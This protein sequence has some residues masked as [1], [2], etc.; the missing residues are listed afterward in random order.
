MKIKIT[1]G[2]NA[3]SQG[4]LTSTFCYVSTAENGVA[5]VGAHG[6]P[7]KVSSNEILNIV[8]KNEDKIIALFNF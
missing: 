8:D 7:Q 1:F 4:S 6:A 2:S 5:N 3:A